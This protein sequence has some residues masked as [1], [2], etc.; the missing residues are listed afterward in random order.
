MVSLV[1]AAALTAVLFR[2]LIDWIQG[3]RYSTEVLHVSEPILGSDLASLTDY[4]CK[5]MVRKEQKGIRK[6][7]RWLPYL[8]E[9][10]GG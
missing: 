6:E 7:Q 8:I 4:H 9:S 10:I 5:R 2:S 3:N 1:V